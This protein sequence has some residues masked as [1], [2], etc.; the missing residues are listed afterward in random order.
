MVGFTLATG[1]LHSQFDWA[2]AFRA[3][4]IKIFPVEI[5]FEKENSIQWILIKFHKM[6]GL[7]LVR[8]N[9]FFRKRLHYH[10]KFAYDFWLKKL[11]NL[12]KQLPGKLLH[13]SLTCWMESVIPLATILLLLIKSKTSSKNINTLR[14][15]LSTKWWQTDK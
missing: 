13:Y 2:I 6:L 10:P 8:P 7:R 15:K 12:M 14:G 4:E 11:K 9:F 1:F 5:I 3:T